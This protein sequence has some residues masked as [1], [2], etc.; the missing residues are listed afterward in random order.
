[1][2]AQADLTELKLSV[3]TFGTKFDVVLVDPPWEEYLRRAPGAGPD[4]AWN[5]QQIKALEIEA[6]TAIPSFVFLWCVP[7]HLHRPQVCVLQ[8]IGSRS[9]RGSRGHHGHP[10]LC[11]PLVPCLA[12]VRAAGAL[13]APQ[14]M[15]AEGLPQAACTAERAVGRVW[16]AMH[17]ARSWPVD[18]AETKDVRR[19]LPAQ[20]LCCMLGRPCSSA[21]AASC[22][23][24][25][26][27]L[28]G[29][30]DPLS[31]S[32]LEPR[33]E[34]RGAPVR[35]RR[36]PG[37]R[38]GNPTC[39]GNASDAANVPRT[40]AGS[41]P[42]W[43]AGAAVRRAWTQGGTAC[44][45]GA[46]GAARTSAGSRPTRASGTAHRPPSTGTPTPPCSTPRCVGC[47]CQQTRPGLV[48]SDTDIC[49]ACL[50]RTRSRH[51]CQP[52]CTQQKH[53][54][55]HGPSLEQCRPLHCRA[56][57]QGACWCAQQPAGRLASLAAR[58][59]ALPD[60]HQGHCAAGHRRAHHPRQHRHRYHRQ[61]GLQPPPAGTSS[62]SPASVL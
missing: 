12:H 9:G 31:W 57:S 42:V 28:A 18:P 41:G 21:P 44:R 54:D 6:I 45:S 38:I 7:L 15:Q 53:E 51:H 13:A 37:R 50:L 3:D 49:P 22:S 1:M 40:T 46:S 39:A 2:R 47:T 61:V 11:L 23:L 8:N 59:G 17:V 35:Q 43:G 60:G 32:L 33:P 52:P 48:L 56:S 10:L 27:A 24:R 20:P 34:R 55:S 30:L 25:G 4:T 16:H 5:W 19:I 58:A 36:G 26:L 29:S 14:S 62:R